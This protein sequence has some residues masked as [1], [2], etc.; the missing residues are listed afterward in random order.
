MTYQDSS[1][2]SFSS[3]ASS[4]SCPCIDVFTFRRTMWDMSLSCFLIEASPTVLALDPII[5][6]LDSCHLRHQ[7]PIIIPLICSW[8]ILR[9]T[10]WFSTICLLSLLLWLSKGDRLPCCP[11][12]LSKLKRLN[13]PLRHGLVRFLCFYLLVSHSSLFLK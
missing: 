12:T 2:V 7:L 13:L 5:N 4:N 10:H 9:C 8:F 6:L 1:Q 11:K 3:S